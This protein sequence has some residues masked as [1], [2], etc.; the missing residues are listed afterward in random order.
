MGG[1]S[2]LRNHHPTP[3]TPSPQIRPGQ[4]KW[5]GSEK[6][7][8][9]KMTRSTIHYRK[10]ALCTTYTKQTHRKKA[11]SGLVITS[12]PAK[13][14][15]PIQALCRPNT[16][17]GPIQALCRPRTASWPIQAQNSLLAQYKPCACRGCSRW[18][19][20]LLFFLSEAQ[21]SPGEF[22]TR[23]TITQTLN[24][25]MCSRRNMTIIYI[26]PPFK[27]NIL[28]KNITVVLLSFLG[29]VVIKSTKF[30]T[31]FPT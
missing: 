11:P 25:S 18:N 3:P 17:L 2:E 19:L 28:Q 10:Y 4:V 30:L 14:L 7:T 5:R 16:A 24:I 1:V 6:K 26:S 15:G 27:I 9:M 20:S 12:Q 21:R 22:T 31:D 8:R 13:P 29:V 23:Y